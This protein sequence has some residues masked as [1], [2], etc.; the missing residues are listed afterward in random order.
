MGLMPLS[1]VSLASGTEGN[2]TI[3]SQGGGSAVGTGDAFDTPVGVVL[4]ST[5][6]RLLVA[7]AGLDAI[8][9]VSLASGTEGN[10][11]ILS[12]GGS[13]SV[14][15]GD[16]VFDTPRSLVLESTNNRLLVADAGLDAIVAVSPGRAVR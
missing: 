4:D 10:R 1:A 3:F 5:N 2:R 11:T 16:I 7:D 8:V 14:G 9:A 6:N 15:S 12:R 13:S